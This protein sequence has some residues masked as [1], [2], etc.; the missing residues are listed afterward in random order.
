ML[1]W[2]RDPLLERQES[3][4]TGRFLG[5][6]KGHLGFHCFPFNDLEGPDAPQNSFV[7][8]KVIFDPTARESISQ[9]EGNHRLC[10]KN[11]IFAA[12]MVPTYVVIKSQGAWFVAAHNMQENKP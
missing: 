11:S 4:V 9:T 10:W 2:F 12:A 3:S 8:N 6:N 7:S 1:C 5:G